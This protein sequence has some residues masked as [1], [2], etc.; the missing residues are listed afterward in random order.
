MNIF[1]NKFIHF[2]NRISQTV[3][4][5]L[6]F[7]KSRKIVEDIVMRNPWN[8]TSLSNLKFNRNMSSI[9]SFIHDVSYN[10]FSFES[11]GL[12]MFLIPRS[13]EIQR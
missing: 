9:Q 5:E 8:F 10:A 1:A 2:L 3:A 11:T 4:Y 7:L 6:N 13:R 12:Y